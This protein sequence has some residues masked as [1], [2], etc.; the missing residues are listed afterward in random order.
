MACNQ[1][2]N[3]NPLALKPTAMG[4]IND[5]VILAD[6][7]TDQTALGDTILSYFEAPYPVS[8]GLPVLLVPTSRILSGSR[9]EFPGSCRC[10]TA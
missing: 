9:L 3:N 8:F 10:R 2:R 1:K 4:R 5:V 6:Q 7:K